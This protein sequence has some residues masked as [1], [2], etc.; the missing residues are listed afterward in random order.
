MYESEKCFKRLGED[1]KSGSQISSSP[2]KL[3]Q[4][5]C[6]PLAVLK[7]TSDAEIKLLQQ[8]YYQGGLPVLSWTSDTKG[9]LLRSQRPCVSSLFFL[10]HS[11]GEGKKSYNFLFSHSQ[12][13]IGTLGDKSRPLLQTMEM[14]LEI[15]AS[16]NYLDD[17]NYYVN[18]SLIFFNLQKK[19]NYELILQKSALPISIVDTGKLNVDI[20]SMH[21]NG[22]E[23]L[24]LDF[25]V[26]ITKFLEFILFELMIKHLFIL[27]Y[28]RLLKYW[29]NM[30]TYVLITMS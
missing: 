1:M 28:L 26:L 13:S 20:E 27:I 18:V 17:L 9:K 3:Y 5:L 30:K 4:F 6:H 22:R 19:K 14:E 21:I 10:S 15:S 12:T 16:L 24:F 7:A 8:F 25:P 11:V 23:L 2:W 29:Y